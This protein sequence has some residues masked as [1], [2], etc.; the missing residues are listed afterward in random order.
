MNDEFNV[1]MSPL[2][3]SISSGGKT[4]Q[5][6]IYQDEK[7]MWI[8]EVVDEFNNSTVWDD[9]FKSDKDA[10]TEVKKNHISRRYQFAD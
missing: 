9:P 8:L 5:V 1:V 4:V 2:C 10:L 3:Q 7:G 6:E